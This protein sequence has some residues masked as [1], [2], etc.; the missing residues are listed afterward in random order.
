MSN[1]QR[2]KEIHELLESDDSRDRNNAILEIFGYTDDRAI[3]LFGKLLP[4]LE[5]LRANIDD[6]RA[7]VEALKQQKPFLARLWSKKSAAK[8]S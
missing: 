7:K 8:T 6:L 2:A 4:A 1:E 5:D 3:E